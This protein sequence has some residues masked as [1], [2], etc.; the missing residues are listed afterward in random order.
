MTALSS[1]ASCIS[2]SPPTHVTTQEG[3]PHN[4]CKSVI[5]GVSSRVPFP[6]PV[7][8]KFYFYDRTLLFFISERVQPSE[9]AAFK[10]SATCCH[11]I[12]A[13]LVF[14]M[15]TLSPTPKDIFFPPLTSTSRTSI[16]HCVKFIFLAFLLSPIV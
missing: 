12:K 1:G 15:P 7:A 16:S 3:L 8:P 5:K 2:V 6:L 13:C 9:P 4:S 11:S 14:V 10:A